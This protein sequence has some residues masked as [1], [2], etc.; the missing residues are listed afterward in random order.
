M[1]IIPCVWVKWGWQ[2]QWL[3]QEEKTKA[4]HPSVPCPLRDVA[5][6]WGVMPA[7]LWLWLAGGTNYSSNFSLCSS[8]G[9]F[10]PLTKPQ[11]KRL[12]T[13]RG[14]GQHRAFPEGP[15]PGLTC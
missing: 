8:L 2:R 10:D 11:L 1:N 5:S 13:P 4:Q 9:S 12:H 15:Q 3:M 7:S 14:G 6:P